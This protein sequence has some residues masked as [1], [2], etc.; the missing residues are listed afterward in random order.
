MVLETQ[1]SMTDELVPFGE[2]VDVSAAAVTAIGTFAT[3]TLT[4]TFPRKPDAHR[5]GKRGPR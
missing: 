3:A 5:K 1:D 4:D 2:A